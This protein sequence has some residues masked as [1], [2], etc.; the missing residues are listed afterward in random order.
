MK[1]ASVVLMG[2]ALVLVS[3]AAQ[4]GDEL[5]I[6]DA[7]VPEAPPTAP[8]MAAYMVL[9]NGSDEPRAIRSA[10]APGFDRVELH[11]SKME[12]G[13]AKMIEQD[14]IVV[15]ANGEQALEPG[16]YHIMLIGIQERRLAGDVVPVTLHF[17][18]GETRV[19]DAPVKKRTM[20]GHGMHH[21]GH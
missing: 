9:E 4:A 3:A 2:L 18:N 5:V 6:R 10:E 19:V 21:H 7:W 17:E 8:A 20:G 16:G 13:L 14:R 15:P 11:L 12:D 1:R